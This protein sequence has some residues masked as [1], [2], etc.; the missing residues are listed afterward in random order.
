[1]H[2]LIVGISMILAGIT[3]SIGFVYLLWLGHKNDE[4]LTKPNTLLSWFL[5]IFAL[6]SVGY[7]IMFAFYTGIDII[8]RY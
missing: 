3:G 6:F 4:H 5:L 8:M 2:E 7:N 1:M